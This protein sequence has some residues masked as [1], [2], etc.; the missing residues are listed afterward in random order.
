MR[1]TEWLQQTRLMR[2]EDVYEGWTEKRLTQEEAA[3]L[4]SGCMP[5]HFSPHHQPI[6]GRRAD[7]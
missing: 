3:Q 2:F 1:R 6:R 7:R 4:L 5:L